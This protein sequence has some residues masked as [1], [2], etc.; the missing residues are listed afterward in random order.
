MRA[1]SSAVLFFIL[2][3]LGLG[4]GPLIVGNMSDYLTNNTDLGPD[5]LRWAMLIAVLAMYP[6]TILWHLGAM[7]LPKGE[8]NEDG[9][10]AADALLTQGA[11]GPQPG[12][13]AG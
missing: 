11:G 5:A 10:N 3:L 6:L 1:M 9:E 4:L 7:A 2:N 8:L 12:S 13:G